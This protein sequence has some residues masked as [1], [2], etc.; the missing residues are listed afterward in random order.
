KTMSKI[1]LGAFAVVASTLSMAA[2]ASNHIADDKIAVAKAAIEHAEQAGAPEAA[3]VELAAARDK[4]ARAQKANAD[5]DAKPAAA[6]ADQAN[7]DA[8][9]AEA[10]AA[11]QR[12]KKAAGEFDNGLQTLRQEANRAAQPAQQ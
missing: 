6:W 5:H 12:S 10:T 8:Q 11:Q 7:L 2:W 4:L 3:P 1:S 9:V